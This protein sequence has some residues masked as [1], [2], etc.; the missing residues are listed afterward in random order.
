MAPQN[1]QSSPQNTRDALRE[2]LRSL[3]Y[4]VDHTGEN[5]ANKVI[6]T[7]TL[8]DANRSDFNHIVPKAAPFYAHSVKI[9]HV[10]TNDV[11]VNGQDF[12]CVGTFAKAVADVVYHREVN[13]AIIFDNPKISGEYRIEYQ[14][15]GGEFVLDSQELAEV[16]ANYLENPRTGDWEQVVGRPLLFPPLPHK[17]H[18]NDFVGM[19]A[20]VDAT[21][22]VAEAIRALLVDEEQAHPGYGQVLTELFRQQRRQDKFQQDL[23]AVRVANTQSTATISQQL[24]DEI[25]RVERESK[26]RDTALENKITDV[27]QTKVN[28]IDTAYKAADKVLEGKIN[29]A[30]SA[31]E[32]ALGEKDAAL[33]QLIDQ[34]DTAQTQAR[35]T[36]I[37]GLNATITSNDRA[38]RQA[39]AQADQVITRNIE[40]AK[41]TLQNS[42]AETTRSLTASIEEKTGE[43]RTGLELKIGQLTNSITALQGTVNGNKRLS[44]SGDS[45][46]T[47][48]I[49]KEIEDR[50]R[51]VTAANNRIGQIETRLNGHEEFVKVG[52]VDQVI[53]GT[54]TFRNRVSVSSRQDT[55]KISYF[56][57]NNRDTHIYNGY[58]SKYLQLRN[59]G[60]LDYDNKRVLLQ[61]DLDDIN[62]KFTEAKRLSDEADTTITAKLTKEIEDRTREVAAANTRIGQVE[63]RLNGNTE[64]VKTGNVNQTIDG[65]KTFRYSI[66]F[67]SHQ[68][69]T[70]ISYLGSNSTDVHLYNVYSG[71]FLQLRNNGQLDYDSKRVLLQP[72]LD[73]LLS[74]NITFRGNKDFANRIVAPNFEASKLGSG[75]FVDQYNKTAPYYVQMIENAA[76]SEYYPFI[77]GRILNSNSG[78]GAAV[79][80]GALGFPAENEFPAGIVHL[81]TDQNGGT[82]NFEWW[83]RPNGDFKAIHGDIVNNNDQ[84][85]S[86]AVFT[87]GDQVIRG[88]K[89]FADHSVHFTKGAEK[90]SIGH[91]GGSAGF[92]FHYY[93]G[94]HRSTNPHFRLRNE[95]IE[96]QAGQSRGY[97][98][99]TH[100]DQLIEGVK[101]FR[102]WFRLKREDDQ[103]QYSEFSYEPGALLRYWA[104]GYNRLWI[105]ND[106]CLHAPRG[107]KV[108][109]SGGRQ[110]ADYRWT[111]FAV[112]WNDS[113]PYLGLYGEGGGGAAA[114]Y[115]RLSVH[116]IYVRSDKRLKHDIERI[117]NASEKLEKINGY[118]YYLNGSKSKS[119]GV[120][121]QEVIEVLPEI[122]HKHHSPEH[123]EDMYSVQ[124][125]GIIA[126][127]VESLKEANQ[128]I[129][130]LEE[131]LNV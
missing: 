46:V 76:R 107:F 85:L 63:T 53:D 10:Q 106:G 30:K 60:Q 34:K 13:W 40:T 118:T 124:Y 27:V 62:S 79:S 104:D 126:L 87:G 39:F 12:Y 58:S 71:K 88:T 19:E 99:G 25:R 29:T 92:L 121:A 98:V 31:L 17:V 5:P 97:A 56:G 95:G 91:E 72:D 3:V 64:F 61:P 48:K 44:D 51:E 127:L 120:I 86:D 69:A 89:S 116:D 130:V 23:D 83:F 4:E 125:H 35:T 84:R 110:D 102:H 6:E 67:A 75:A 115:G 113:D 82:G 73:N 90:M 11:L 119:G 103:G 20:Q 15:I 111:R 65:T 57:S 47:A 80:F 112:N 43:V 28:Q 18:A 93:E 114:N 14:T 108:G 122:V 54:K 55:T 74:N 81:K 2:R 33:R 101:T 70:K 22:A 42:I 109:N 16:L 37:S 78:W 96:L 68:D 8:T 94:N 123:N 128:R 50:T 100:G 38:V 117:T 21:K 26:E 131:K 129:K 52:N 36:A 32:T 59:D 1:T 66:Q 7:R 9:T 77:K 24:T 45:T 105:D 49:T 41:T